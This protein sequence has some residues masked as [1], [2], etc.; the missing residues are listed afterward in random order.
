MDF[1]NIETFMLIAA[2]VTA[3]SGALSAAIK[4][5]VGTKLL[6]LLSWIAG[7]I[8]GVLLARAFGAPTEIGIVAGLGGSGGS[9]A[10]Y[11]QLSQLK[12]A[13]S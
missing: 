2:I 13:R 1:V 7:V 10:I 12:K 11:D 4:P 9:N 8:I 5:L 3:S 6:P